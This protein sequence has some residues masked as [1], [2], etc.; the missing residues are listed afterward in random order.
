MK[1]AR[2]WTFRVQVETLPGEV[3]GVTGS[4]PELGEWRVSEKSKIVLLNKEVSSPSL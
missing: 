2:A 1:H 4:V 3:V